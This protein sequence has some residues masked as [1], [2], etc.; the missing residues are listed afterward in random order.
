MLRLVSRR[1]A[2]AQSARLTT[3]GAR[4]YANFPPHTVIDMPALSPTMSQGNVGAWKKKVGDELQPGDVLVE[5]ETD[6]ATMDFEFQ[7]DGYLA[8]ILVPEGTKDVPVGV[9]I[10]VYVADADDVGA[11]KDFKAS[12][13]GGPPKKEQPK[14]AK[15]ESKEPKEEP[16]DSGAPKAYKEEPQQV[17]KKSAQAPIAGRI[18]ASPLAKTIALEKGLKLSDIKGTGPNGRIIKR[19]V[20]NAQPSAPAAASAAAFKDTPISSMRQTIA[21]RLTESKQTNPD[22]IVSS[23]VSV[24]KLL[25]LRK[26]LNAQADG[27]Y[28][29]SVNDILIKAV[30]LA[31]KKVPAANTHW[32]DSEK[33][34]R[35]YS[36]VDVS[37]AVATPSGLIT[38]VLKNADS[39]GLA[40]ISAQA[41]DLGKRA[42]DGKLKPEEYQGGTITISNMGMNHAVSLFT[43]II[44]PPQSTIL[45]VGTT[46][47]RAVEDPESESGIAFDDVMTL[48]ASF[49]HKVVDG[50]VGAEWM[51]ALKTILENPLH[52]LL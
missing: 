19:D 51:K 27:A 7:D 10:G 28:K 42:R 15:E 26:A 48:T 39:L 50:A 44:N 24:S 30:A 17:P 22:Y 8:Q 41:K 3:F 14:Q 47:R 2:I 23:T 52:L 12:D 9:P 16:E 34:T 11:F 46:E 21:R 36:T 6:K 49:D 31:C 38:P 29:L 13:A 33:V 40:S 43:A 35:E 4:F 18:N 5:I 1:V 20:E 45:A 25:E 37:I 32:I